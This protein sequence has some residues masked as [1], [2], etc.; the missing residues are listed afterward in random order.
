[1]ATLFGNVVVG[2]DKCVD[3]G[4]RLVGWPSGG[5]SIQNHA[6]PSTS[7]PSF[8]FN[9]SW[10]SLAFIPLALFITIPTKAPSA[11]CFPER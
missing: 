8:C 10:T 9:R 4:D 6:A 11:V 2:R 1:M 5:I 3:P 7:H